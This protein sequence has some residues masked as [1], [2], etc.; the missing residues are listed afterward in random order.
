[1]WPVSEAQAVTDRTALI[2]EAAERLEAEAIAKSI[3]DDNA[4]WFKKHWPELGSFDAHGMWVG[5]RRQFKETYDKGI[6]REALMCRDIYIPDE[7]WDLLSDAQV[8]KL[9]TADVKR[10]MNRIDEADGGLIKTTGN[11]NYGPVK[12]KPSLDKYEI[13]E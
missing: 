12:N 7:A 13:D 4:E 2:A 5:K 1:M 6:V 10:E 3:Q 8:K 11:W 9:V